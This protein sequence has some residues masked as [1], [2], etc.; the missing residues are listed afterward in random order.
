MEGALS[1]RWLPRVLKGLSHFFGHPTCPRPR[2]LIQHN[3]FCLPLVAGGMIEVIGFHCAFQLAVHLIR[4][5]RIPEPPAP[6]VAGPD[7]DAQLPGN[8][9]RRTG[10]TKEKGR[11]N[12]VRQRPLAPVKRV[13]GEVVEGAFAAMTPVAFTSGAIAVCPPA[14]RHGG[15]GTGDIGA[16]DPSHRSVWM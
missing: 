8:T 7:M 14:D 5:G 10:K 3:N 2:A 4:Q 15:S 6:A 16:T 12:P 11:Q 1:S 9:S 13:R